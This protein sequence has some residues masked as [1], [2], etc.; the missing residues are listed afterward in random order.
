MI[1]NK[2]LNI[3]L[4]SRMNPHDIKEWSGTMYH[5]YHKLREK[6]NVEIMGSELFQQIF[7]FSRGNHSVVTYP[8]G[9]YFDKISR[10]LSERVNR[11]DVDVIFFGDILLVPLAC[12]APIVAYSDI[13]FEQRKQYM[14]A[15][16]KE[17][18]D[19]CLR[20]EKKFLNI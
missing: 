3:A 4:L 12:K 15:P 13:D 1:M 2:S 19:I 10:L 9:K 16:C 14:G 20:S 18:I 11:M 5:I 8:E 6:H 7:F 17:V